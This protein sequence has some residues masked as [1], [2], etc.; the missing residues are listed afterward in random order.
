MTEQSKPGDIGRRA[1]EFSLCQF[2][3]G[4]I[5]L[6]HQR[7]HFFLKRARREAAFDGGCGDAG[8]ERLREDEEISNSC[9]GVGKDVPNIDEPGDREAVNRFRIANRMS[10]DDCTAN[11]GGFLETAAQNS[12]DGF[13]RNQILRK[14]H[15]IQRRDWPTAHGENIRERIRGGDLSVSEWIVDDGCEEIHGLDERAVVVQFV[16]AGVIERA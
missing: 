7:D 16:N 5:Y 1:N 3:A 14:T 9:G 10:A 4:G 11:F 13:W 15:K 8:S 12:R 2:G 6:R